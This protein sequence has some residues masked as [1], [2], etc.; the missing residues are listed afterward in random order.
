MKSTLSV[1]RTTANRAC[2]ISLMI[3]TVLVAAAGPARSADEPTA[4]RTLVD[5]EKAD[6]VQLRASQAT[7]RPVAGENGQALEIVTE[8]D[9]K[10]PSV[11]LT[12]REGKWDLS[13][14]YAV[15]IDIANPEDKPVR[16]LL[17]VNNPGAN[18]Q[19]N[20]NTESVTIP[21]GSKGVL[22]LP[23]GN[24]HGETNHPI[25]QANVISAVVML[26]RAGRSARFVVDNLRAIP[27]GSGIAQEL[28]A[29]DFFQQMKPVLGR[30][31]NLGNMLE[32]PREGEWGVRVKEEY[33]DLIQSAGFDS[34]R[35]P[36]RWSS[37]AAKDAPYTIDPKFLDRVEWVVH[38]AMEHRLYAVLNM[39]HYEEIFHQ[40][41]QHRERFLAMW[42][43]IAERFKACPEALYFELLNEPHE[44]LDAEKW[45]ALAAEALAVV[46]KT[47]P[48]R[49][50]VIGPADWNGI[51]ALERLVLPEEDRNLI[52]TFHYYKPF[53]FTHQGAGW[54]G[55]NA[56]KWL[57]TTWTAT[58]A[59]R[60]AVIND[61]DK[62]L[63]WSVEHQRPVYMGEFGAYS[64]A[65]MQS[66]ARWTRFLATEAARRKIASAYWEFC[67]SFGVYDPDQAVWRTPLKSALLDPLAEDSS[68]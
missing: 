17:S 5:F 28:M 12:P 11:T 14:Y 4:V 54:V 48:S 27:F 10:W 18:G 35:I 59:Q 33:F 15:E 19:K 25:D 36:V 52:A 61:L 65:D 39:H 30:G 44:K 13:G 68:E 45:N 66:R 43:Q 40:P 60:Q 62:A 20:C 3:L 21:A 32:A 67:S 56:N 6:S 7:A 24:W 23:F 47:N 58:P 41:D 31:V 29:T 53:Q 42:G 57:G 9:A 22:H 51:D 8:A 37:H 34:V 64:K 2:R 50:V 26:D 63:A 55:T 49:M 16:V 1:A 46:R 38:Q